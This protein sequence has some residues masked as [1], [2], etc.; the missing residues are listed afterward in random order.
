VNDASILQKSI[1]IDTPSGV[2]HLLPQRAI[3][4]PHLAS[5][6]IADTHFG[7]AANFRLQGLAVPSGTTQFML[8]DL[9]ALLTGTGA[10]ELVILGDLIHSSRSAARDFVDDLICWR[11]AHS[12]LR[13]Q[14][15]RGNH[16]RHNRNLIQQLDIDVI[17]EG[18]RMTDIELRHYPT[19]SMTDNAPMTSSKN[20]VLCGHL[21]PGCS[22]SIGPRVR[23]TFPCFVIE[24]SQII[25]PAFGE[26]T[27]LARTTPDAMRRIFCCI[28]NELIEV[29]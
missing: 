2:V 16:D 10:R 14:L 26:F 17:E 1:A 22:V 21:H 24:R 6:F 5:L 15:V 19:L 9:S 23:K 20:L 8:Q 28:E 18:A 7:K 29:F 11:K 12:N 3:W 13:I 4:L 25:L 27:G